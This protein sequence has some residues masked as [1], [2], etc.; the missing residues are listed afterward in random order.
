MESKARIERKLQLAI[1]KANRIARREKET[2]EQIAEEKANCTDEITKYMS[3]LG[4]TSYE[5]EEKG[6]NYSGIPTQAYTCKRIEPKQIIYNANKVA[7]ALGKINA[8]AIIDKTYVINDMQGLIRLLKRHC[9]NPKEF[10]RY[11]NVTSS[12]NEKKLDSLYQ[13]GL[14]TLDDLE[15]CYTVKKRKAYWSIKIKSID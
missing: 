7:E 2:L 10:K 8:G 6:E 3:E 9:V 4:I 15:G 13:T 1:I 11:I 14:V 12:V 5:F